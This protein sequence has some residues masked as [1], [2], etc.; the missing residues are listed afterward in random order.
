LFHRVLMLTIHL[1]LL[2]SQKLV[3]CLQAL[4]ILRNTGHPLLESLSLG[5]NLRQLLLALVVHFCSGIQ[6]LSRS[7]ELVAKTDYLLFE[8][9]LGG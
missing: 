9:L 6:A 7:P 5:R 4:V 1:L 3:A 2:L 8:M